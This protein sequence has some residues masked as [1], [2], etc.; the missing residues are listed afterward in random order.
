MCDVYTHTHT[1]TTHSRL[2]ASGIISRIRVYVSTVRPVC[3]LQYIKSCKVF[4]H[5]PVCLSV[6]VC[7]CGNISC[8]ACEWC[9]RSPIPPQPQRYCLPSANAIISAEFLITN[10]PRNYAPVRS[11][12]DVSRTKGAQWP[13][14]GSRNYTCAQTHMRIALMMRIG[15]LLSISLSHMQ[16][17]AQIMI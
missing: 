17:C 15:R 16:M 12:S 8:S 9:T 10:T 1:H 13:A 11:A 6:C 3:G 4:R 7:V 14:F 2:P 5:G